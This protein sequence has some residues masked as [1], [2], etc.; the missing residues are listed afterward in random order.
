MTP[1]AIVGSEENFDGENRAFKAA[2]SA[3]GINK[4]L[5]LWAR[6]FVTRPFS[7][8][9]TWTSTGPAAFVIRAV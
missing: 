7:F 2:A 5:P 1:K 4:G 3:A 8:T 9:N 6:A